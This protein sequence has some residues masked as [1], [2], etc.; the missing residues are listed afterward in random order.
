MSE[1]LGVL[2]AVLVGT[3]IIPKFAEY[4][5]LS[6]ENTRAAITA[7]QQKQLIAAATTYIRQNSIAIGAIA[8]PTTTAMITVGMLQAPTVNLLP[9][10]FGAANPYGQTWQVEVLEPT[11]GNL[12]AL[13][14]STGGNAVPD[15][16]AGKIA[17][18]VGAAGGLIPLNDS[19]IYPGAAANAYGAYS[20]WTISTANYT[21]VTGGHPAALLA[22]NAGQLVSNYLY[23]SAVPGQPQLNQMNTAI[24][25]NSNDINNIKDLDAV[26]LKSTG[27]ATIGTTLAVAGNI[28]STAGDI[29]IASGKTI[30]TG[31]VM[32]KDVVVEGSGCGG[33]DGLIAKDASGLLLSCQSS[34]WSQQGGTPSTTVAFFYSNSCP[35]GWL[36]ANGTNGTPDMRGMFPR[37]VDLGRGVDPGRWVGQTQSPYAG[38]FTVQTYGDDGDSNS[39]YVWYSTRQIIINGI[40]SGENYNSGV[41]A[42]RT[43]YVTPGDAR[44]YNVALL[45]CMKQ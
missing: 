19:G 15:A 30:S 36:V 4:Q 45:A 24:N 16:Q 2:F 37:G 18:I 14:L 40:W 25:M 29:T 41:T 23:R 42:P 38:S 3:M 8:T 7:Q 43:I 33:S 12:Q 39:S 31:K 6:N 5:K 28:T 32:I 22:F 1:I 44:P 9:A 21:S 13:V 17:A 27:M 34:V 11:A 35:A 26:T 20:G 10:S